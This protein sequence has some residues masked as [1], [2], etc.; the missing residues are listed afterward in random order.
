MTCD[1]FNMP[2]QE[3]KKFM[4]LLHHSAVQNNGPAKT[5]RNKMMLFS[6]KSHEW[7]NVPGKRAGALL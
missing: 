7:E 3:R 6:Y 2:I 1:V 5:Y 4:T